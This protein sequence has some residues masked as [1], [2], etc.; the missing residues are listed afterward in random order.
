ME[1]IS[2][3]SLVSEYLWE[4]NEKDL[5]AVSMFNLMFHKDPNSFALKLDIGSSHDD[6]DFRTKC[7]ALFFTLVN[8]FLPLEK[9]KRV[10]LIHFKV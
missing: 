8:D 1:E 7:V 10:N 2:F 9:F 4:T 6:I 5:V 3:E